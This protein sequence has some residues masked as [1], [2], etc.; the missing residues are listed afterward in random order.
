MFHRIHLALARWHRRFRLAGFPMV[1]LCWPVF[2]LTCIV[3]AIG[4]AVN[5]RRLRRLRRHLV[6]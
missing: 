2:W 6:S 5:E 4:Y 3:F 1:L